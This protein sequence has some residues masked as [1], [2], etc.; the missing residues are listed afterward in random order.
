MPTKGKRRKINNTHRGRNQVTWVPLQQALVPEEAKQHG[1][2]AAAQSPLYTVFVKRTKSH[3][4][5][6]PGP[7]GRPQPMPITHLMIIRNDRKPKEIPWEHKQQVKNELCGAMC[8]AVELFPATWRAQPVKQ[9]HLWVL[10]PG[11]SFPLGLF[12]ESMA[13]SVTPK[14]VTVTK[15]ELEVFVLRPPS[16]DMIE[17]F[18]DEAEAKK[19]YAET[20]CEMTGGKVERIGNVPTVDDGAAWTDAAK[21]KVAN[22]IAKGELLEKMNVPEQPEGTKLPFYDDGPDSVE[23]EIGNGFDLSLLKGHA[24]EVY[25]KPS[26]EEN[27]QIAEFMARELAHLKGEREIRIE[28]AANLLGDKFLEQQKDDGGEAEAAADLDKYRQELLKKKDKPN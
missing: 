25:G 17:V 15:E 8:E 23:E 7:D 18:A 21:A 6:M 13:G 9:C 27:I 22:I 19:M 1:V 2:V 3:G 11:A 14:D 26:T 5:E 16:G 20:G 12:P 4:F 10:T 24:E 28:N